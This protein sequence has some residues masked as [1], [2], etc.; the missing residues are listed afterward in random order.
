MAQQ[1]RMLIPAVL[2]SLLALPSVAADFSNLVV[3]SQTGGG[4]SLMAPREWKQNPKSEHL[5][6][7]SPDGRVA[8]TAS[9][10]HKPDANLRDFA[11]HRFSSVQSF[12]EQV[13]PET[14]VGG[15]VY[16]EYEGVWPNEK[17]P[18]YYVVSAR[19]VDGDF[20]SLTVVTDRADFEK[21]R[22]FYGRIMESGKVSP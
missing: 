3:F 4:V 21:N 1:M 13:G 11:E 19:Q 12:Y 2:V 6:V 8:L 18:T 15:G 16:R 9:A 5:S 14:N 20:V 17:K 22:A 7:G 10:Y